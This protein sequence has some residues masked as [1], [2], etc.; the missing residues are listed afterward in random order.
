MKRI[1]ILY[2]FVV[3][4]GGGARQTDEHDHEEG[5]GDLIEVTDTQMKAVGIEIG[6]IETKNLKSVVRANGQLVLTPQNAAEVNTL[7]SGI[8]KE[9]TVH[10]GTAVRKGQILAFLENL[11]IVKLQESYITQKEEFAYCSQ[12]YERQ[13]E[14][15]SQNAGSGKDLQQARAKYE[16]DRARLTSLETQLRQLNIDVARLSEGVFVDAIPIKAPINGVI[17]NIYVK[18]GSYADMATV[19]M[20]ITDNSQVHCDLQVFEHDLAKIHPGQ[21]VEIGLTNQGNRSVEGVVYTV[22]QSFEKESKSVTV[23][24]EINRS[25]GLLP[26]MYVSALIQTGNEAVSA[27]PADA[28]ADAE[29][30]KYIFALENEEEDCNDFRRIEVTTGVSELGYV[31]IIPLERLEPDT[32]IIVKGA[33]YVMSMMT[34]GGEH[35]H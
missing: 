6:A 11:D 19:L 30:K 13:K 22:N 32:K 35:E 17:G 33:F 23:H 2:L 12:E 5:H 10:E 1:L 34:G 7:T 14:L 15:A 31:E 26:G 16:A 4:C 9:I 28:I 27:V 21:S 3:S 25:E 18:T 24:V 8:I 29:G 20:E